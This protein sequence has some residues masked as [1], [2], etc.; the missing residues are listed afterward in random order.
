[1]FIRGIVFEPT[2]SSGKTYI[3]NLAS[4]VVKK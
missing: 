3:N 4:E 1:M 2:F